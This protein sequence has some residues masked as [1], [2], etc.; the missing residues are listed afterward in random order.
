MEH[1]Y[2]LND[3]WCDIQSKVAYHYTEILQPTKMFLLVIV[4][5]VLLTE[6]SKDI[7]DL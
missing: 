6:D 3:E 4:K 7:Q 1:W 5:F 2:L